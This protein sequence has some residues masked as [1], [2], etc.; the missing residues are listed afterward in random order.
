MK[1]WDFFDEVYRCELLELDIYRKVQQLTG[2]FDETKL[3]ILS[4]DLDYYLWIKEDEL[5]ASYSR[6]EIQNKVDELERAGK[7]IPMIDLPNW[8]EKMPNKVLDVKKLMSHHELFCLYQLRQLLDELQK[9]QTGADTR[10]RK[11]CPNTIQAII[12]QDSGENLRQ[13]IESLKKHKLISN[14]DTDKIIRE[15][16][17]EPQEQPE[18]INWLKSQRLLIY[19]LVQLQKREFIAHEN[20]WQL[21]SKH[22]LIKGKAV[23]SASLKSEASNILA[24]QPKGYQQI[25][26]ILESIS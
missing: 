24:E 3:F 5:L 16:F 25:D 23:R 18:P 8:S 1:V 20:E 9:K 12:W 6:E 11:H 14:T 2:N 21:Y 22:F 15:H 10:Q 26:T 4:K 19:L 17:K 13:L 7:K